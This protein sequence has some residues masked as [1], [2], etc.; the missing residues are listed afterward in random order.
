MAKPWEADIDV[1]HD[2]AARLICTQFT[3]LYG[4]LEPFGNGWDNTAFLLGGQWVFRFPRRN[5][6]VDL[7]AGELRVLPTL[8]PLLPMPVPAPVFVGTATEEYPYPFFG[9]R[10]IAGTT[11]DRARLDDA[12]RC[13]LAGPLADVLRVLH[14]VPLTVADELGIPGDAFG[15][16]DVE[17]CLPRAR[18]RLSGLIARGDATAAQVAV[19]GGIMDAA[20]GCRPAEAACILHGDLYMRHLIVAS[21]ALRGIIDWGDCHRGDPAMDLGLV[22]A[23]LPARGQAIFA[24]RYG[25]IAADTRALARFRAVVVLG[26]LSAFAHDIGD[27]D[28]VAEVRYAVGVLADGN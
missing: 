6:A 25:P 23:A 28:L 27:A 22:F 16:L 13:A 7:L 2:L 3:A 14:R 9:Y 26:H 4:T 18:E 19:L 15:R 11:A 1:T 24:E 21:G 8:A 20:R 17:K 10:L 5:S 12:A